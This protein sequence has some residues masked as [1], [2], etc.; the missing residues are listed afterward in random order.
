MA[1]LIPNIAKGRVA[2]LC[3]LGAANDSL[4]WVL[5]RNAET[6]ANIRDA[7][8]LAALIALAVDEATFAGYARVPAAG[9]LV[10]PDNV[11]DRQAVDAN[12]P[13]WNPTA[14]QALT[15]IVLC[16]DYTTLAGTDADVIPLFVD[17]FATTTNTS[18]V[19]SYVVAAGGFFRAS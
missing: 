13:T 8:S 17:D 3:L 11:N 18:G 7:A 19:L 6:D 14:A 16:Y 10:T 9:V 12:D 1:A 5:L 4:F 15:R 2:E